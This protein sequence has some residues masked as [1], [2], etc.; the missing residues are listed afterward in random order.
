MEAN[1]GEGLLEKD[2]KSVLN[3][4]TINPNKKAVK[5]SVVIH[6]VD[7]DL[8]LPLLDAVLTYRDYISAYGDEIIV[9][10]AVGMG[11]YIK[12]IYPFRDNLE[13]SLV[14][15]DSKYQTTL[16]YKA[17]INSGTSI[18]KGEKYD[19]LTKEDLDKSEIAT[20]EIQLID[21]YVE[22]LRTTPIDG[23][24]RFCNVETCVKGAF[25]DTFNSSKVAGRNPKMKFNMVP[26]NNTFMYKHIEIPTGTTILNLPGY[27]QDTQYGIYNG[28]VGT[29]FQ[30]YGEKLEETL[31]VF[32]LYSTSVF[33]KAVKKMVI[34]KSNNPRLDMVDNTYFLDGDIVKIIAGSNTIAIDNSDAKMISD[35]GDVVTTSPDKMMQRNNIAQDGKVTYVNSTNLKGNSVKKRA[36]GSNSF[37]YVGNDSN[38]YKH[39]S[40]VLESNSKHF[41]VIW[42]YSAPEHVYPGMPVMYVYEDVD[43]G[44][45][46]L[47]G[48]VSNIFTN[49][50]GKD[51]IINSII[52]INVAEKY[53]DET[54]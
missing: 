30:L 7:I 16:R 38:P 1:L 43:Y 11:T 29:Y 19:K 41:R 10:V 3:A 12:D 17:V 31:F 8:P 46:K 24:F 27:L 47:Y 51:R 48:V 20:L 13:M 39:R 33:D 34:F 50:Q 25:N 49:Y 2:I 44:I 28:K 45:V 21:R 9:M 54:K 6:T 14:R 52:D 53:D 36:D 4:K 18:P 15:Q 42:N 22:L 23:V 35:G 5:Y 40:K 26:P 32:P 37:T